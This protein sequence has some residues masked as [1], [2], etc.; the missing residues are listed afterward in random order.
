MILLCKEVNFAMPAV[1]NMLLIPHIQQF[2]VNGIFKFVVKVEPIVRTT[3]RV[4]RHIAVIAF[5]VKGEKLLGPRGLLFK[6][7]D[8]VCHFKISDIFLNRVLRASL[9]LS[10]SFEDGIC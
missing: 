10:D 1:I 5:T 3:D 8:G 2:I 9:N 6:K 4:Q 7:I